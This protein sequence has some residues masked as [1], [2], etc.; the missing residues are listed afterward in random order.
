M[1]MTKEGGGLRV[2]PAMTGGT[3]H[4]PIILSAFI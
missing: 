2:E 4:L 1:I 3:I